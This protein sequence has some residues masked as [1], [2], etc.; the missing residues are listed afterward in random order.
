MASMRGSVHTLQR[1]SDYLAARG[2]VPPTHSALEFE[3]TA[4]HPIVYPKMEPLNLAFLDAFVNSTVLEKG[5]RLPDSQTPPH[6]NADADI[7]LAPSTPISTPP[8]SSP[9]LSA[10]SSTDSPP[11]PP[12][13]IN[14][15]CDARLDRLQ[16][17]FW[18][19]VPITDDLAASAI[20]F[21]L[22][23]D[24]PIMGV[25]DPDLFLTD[26][27]EHRLTF[28]SPFLVTSILHLACVGFFFLFV[29]SLRNP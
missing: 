18:T 20:S 27:V 29:L 4:R 3:L 24:H 14:G 8:L 16:I 28:C 26:L 1:P 19:K 6:L 22:E 11:S 9:S 17:N 7:S 15:F 12:Q 2:I 13:Q 21:Y 25:F 5:Y 10:V 23:N